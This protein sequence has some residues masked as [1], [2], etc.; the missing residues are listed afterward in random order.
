MPDIAKVELGNLQFIDCGRRLYRLLFAVESLVGVADRSLPVLPSEI[1]QAVRFSLVNM[2]DAIGLSDP[3]THN[4]L[5][6]HYRRYQTYLWLFYIITL[7]LYLVA[8]FGLVAAFEY[9]VARFGDSDLLKIPAAIVTLLTAAIVI[10]IALRITWLLIDRFFADTLCITGSLS[11]V[12]E[13]SRDDVLS[14][15]HRRQL[16]VKRFYRLAHSTHLLALRF[17]STSEINQTWLDHHFRKMKLYVRERERWVVAPTSTTL[18]DLRIDL[19]RLAKMYISAQYGDFVW[20][21]T[22]VDQES[23]PAPSRQQRVA[24]LVARILGIII[25]VGLFSL[26]RLVPALTSMNSPTLDL[27]LAAWFLL[28]VDGALGLGIV[29]RLLGVARAIRDIR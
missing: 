13:L 29:D 17:A 14:D 25:P 7:L 18:H 28:T 16:L 12:M 20:S 6:L 19:Y 11:I 10:R 9:A 2:G 15:P 1:A 8:V 24:N 26:L 3:I 27:I 22:L 23:R 5:R 21:A 4:L